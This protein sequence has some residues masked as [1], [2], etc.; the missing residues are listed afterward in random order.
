MSL[1]E[2][3]GGYWLLMHSLCWHCSLL[4]SPP[5]QHFPFPSQLVSLS[6][7]WFLHSLSQSLLLFHLSLSFPSASLWP[8]PFCGPLIFFLWIFLP[9]CLLSP[10]SFWEDWHSHERSIKCYFA[11]GRFQ[12]DSTCLWSPEKV[13]K[14]GEGAMESRLLKRML[15][16]GQNQRWERTF[17]SDK[18]SENK[19]VRG[20]SGKGEQRLLLCWVWG[21]LSP[22]AGTHLEGC[23][24]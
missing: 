6:S 5:P 8:V 18:S 7:T 21:L 24:P 10:S 9:S 2:N 15:R 3:V 14:L 4:C 16:F 19:G 20:L 23:G 13:L 12:A 1:K 11:P 22:G 17:P